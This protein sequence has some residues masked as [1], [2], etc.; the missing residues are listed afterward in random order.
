MQASV[1]I[2]DFPIL[3][4]QGTFPASSF[5]KALGKMMIITDL[6]NFQKDPSVHV[7]NWLGLLHFILAIHDLRTLSWTICSIQ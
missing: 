2:C 7:T 6:W 1:W 5:A 3:C 4:L